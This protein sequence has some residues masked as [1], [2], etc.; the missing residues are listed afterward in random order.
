MKR[1]HSFNFY[2]LLGIFLVNSLVACQKKKE[3]EPT[4]EETP[5]V[6][7]TKQS[8]QSGSSAADAV[9]EDVND[10]IN[11]KLNPE[12]SARM[13]AYNLPC[14]VVSVDTTKNSAG[15]KVYE[16]KYGNKTPCGYKK[17]SGTVTFELLKGKT[18]VDTGAEYKIIYKDYVVEVLANND[19]I[20]INGFI[21][22]TNVS[23][24]QF[25]KLLQNRLL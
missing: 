13:E 5:V 25:G 17:K 14:G 2:V 12:V 7:S 8:D 22:N 1:F 11:N 10:Y 20:K 21:I 16:M 15:N 9:L 23:V 6:A 18:F 3:V 24:G 19:I 4:I